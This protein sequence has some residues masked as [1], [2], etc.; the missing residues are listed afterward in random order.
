M[1]DCIFIDGASVFHF[2][3][4]IP[5]IFRNSSIQLNVETIFAQRSSDQID[6]F[7]Q[8]YVLKL[9]DYILVAYSAI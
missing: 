4:P 5:R 7:I 8:K 9:H 6:K 2:N 1:L 3:L